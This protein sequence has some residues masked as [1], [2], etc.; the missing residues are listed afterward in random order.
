MSLDHR[1][2]EAET[3]VFARGGLQPEESFLD[4]AS[5]T[6]RLRVLSVGT[7]PSL[8]LLH[9]VSL[10]DTV[11]APWLADLAGYRALLV[12]LPGHGLS[13]PVAY[14]PGTVRD[15]S[16]DLMDDLFDALGLATA[17]VVG[18]SLGGMF[19]L[20]YAAARPGRIASLVAIGQPAVALPGATVR[21]PLSRMTVPVLGEVM[22]RTPTP[23][24]VYRGLLGQGL[25]PGA[26]AAAPRELL[27]VLRLTARRKGNAKTVASLMHAIDGFRRPRPESVMTDGEVH[28]ITAP[29]MFCVGTGDP[30]LTPTQARLAHRQDPR[31]GAARSPGRARPPAGGSR[32]LRQAHDRPPHGDGIRACQLMHVAE[33]PHPTRDPSTHHTGS[34]QGFCPISRG[35]RPIAAGLT[36]AVQHSIGNGLVLPTLRSLQAFSRPRVAARLPSPV[37]GGQERRD[38]LSSG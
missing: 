12:E 37:P 8:V 34:G 7:G 20:W 4:L 26:A 32:W 10:A 29:T 3:R 18:H 36:A 23:R 21:M 11:W 24:P 31:S 5:A 14:R 1:I 2:R 19:A 13:G 33:Q 35:C 16:L 25:G 30:Y 6:V 38:D 27:D 17:P 22:L 28:Q 15:H 9:G